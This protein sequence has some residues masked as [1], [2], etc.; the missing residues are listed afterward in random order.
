MN[1]DTKMILEEIRK[2][3]ERMDEMNDR[4]DQMSS[5][6]DKL[7]TTVNK[8]FEDVYAAVQTCYNNTTQQINDVEEHRAFFRK[9]PMEEIAFKGASGNPENMLRPESCQ[10]IGNGFEG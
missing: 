3:N 9:K 8:G 7:D 6:M 2:L 10:Q 1:E 4:M 5:R